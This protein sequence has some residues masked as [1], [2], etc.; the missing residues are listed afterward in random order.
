[1][2]NGKRFNRGFISEKATY[3]VTVNPGLQVNEPVTEFGEVFQVPSQWGGDEVDSLL[4]RTEV[5]D[6]GLWKSSVRGLDGI[7]SIEVGRDANAP[8]KVRPNLNLT[9][10]VG[11]QSSPTA[12]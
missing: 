2:C 7:Q 11:E 4:A 1:M 3:R 8:P 9:A 10:P 5:N 12:R 6:S